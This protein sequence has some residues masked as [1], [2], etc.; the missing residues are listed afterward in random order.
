M[1]SGFRGGFTGMDA[2]V[3]AA[4]P[5]TARTSGSTLDVPKWVT[6]EGTGIRSTATAPTT[7]IAGGICSHRRNPQHGPNSTEPAPRRQRPGDSRT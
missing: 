7:T 4:P 2:Q 1:I 6:P 3:I 5:S